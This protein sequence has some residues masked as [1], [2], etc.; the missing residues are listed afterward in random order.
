MRRVSYLVIIAVTCIIVFNLTVF[1]IRTLYA[2]T[3]RKQ[4]DKNYQKYLDNSVMENGKHCLYRDSILAADFLKK[5]NLEQSGD[6]SQVHIGDIFYSPDSLK[7]MVFGCYAVVDTHD[8]NQSVYYAEIL[9]GVREKTEHVWML[10]SGEDKLFTYEYGRTVPIKACENEN[11]VYDQLRNKYF[12]FKI[13]KSYISVFNDKLRFN[14]KVRET[15]DKYRSIS[16]HY[17]LPDQRFWDD[18]TFIKDNKVNGVYDFQVIES[19]GKRVVDTQDWYI[20]PDT[21]KS[22][23]N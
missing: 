18:L 1:G 20:V 14:G 13:R 7:M 15:K 22:M 23:Y 6:S 16:F 10:Y 19:N 11:E 2:G 5:Y 8:K 4:A 21:I 17:C 3:M 12:S 9:F